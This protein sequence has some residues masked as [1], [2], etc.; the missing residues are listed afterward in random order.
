MLTTPAVKAITL[1]LAGIAAGVGGTKLTTTVTAPIIHV[2]AVDLRQTLGTSSIQ[3]YAYATATTVD[4]K[5]KTATTVDLNGHICPLSKESTAC[6]VK[7]MANS[8]NC[9]SVPR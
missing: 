7:L 8:V 2:H 9:F 1:V 3:S 6:A 5:T 4:I